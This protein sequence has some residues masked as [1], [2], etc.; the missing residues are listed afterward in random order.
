[1]KKLISFSI[2]IL[3]F[4][5][6]KK[7]TLM[8]P[9]LR[10]CM[11]YAMTQAADPWMF[12][13]CGVPPI[14]TDSM[15]ITDYFRNNHLDA[16]YNHI[17]Y[18]DLGIACTSA[19]CPSGKTLYVEV[20]SAD[21]SKLT[22]LH[23]IPCSDVFPTQNTNNLMGQWNYVWISGG[24]AGIDQ[25]MVNEHKWVDFTGTNQ[26]LFYTNTALLEQATYMIGP[27]D[28]SFW[29]GDYG[30]QY[31]VTTG[32]MISQNYSLRNDTLFLYTNVSDGLNYKL[33]RR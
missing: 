17:D 19:M 27:R 1:M 15:M 24:F 3:I 4:A 28:S 33:T 31:N 20:A 21:V 14:P 18:V 12:V 8:P 6:C 7:E 29:G 25:S 13:G 30:I 11:K 26:A 32:S 2:L 23:F 22:A 16:T 10:V 9:Q 5:S